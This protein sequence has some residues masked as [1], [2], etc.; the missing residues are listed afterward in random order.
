MKFICYNLQTN[1]FWRILKI[2]NLFAP[3]YDIPT[4]HIGIG[5]YNM[6]GTSQTQAL[7]GEV[8]PKHCAQTPGEVPAGR[9]GSCNDRVK[10][11]R[12]NYDWNGLSFWNLDS[13]GLKL[14]LIHWLI[15][16]LVGWFLVL[17]LL[18]DVY[19]GKATQVVFGWSLVDFTQLLIYPIVGW[20]GSHISN[21]TLYIHVIQ[22]YIL[23][24]YIYIFIVCIYIFTNIYIYMYV[25]LW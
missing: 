6:T 22:L 23:Y 12:V 25:C 9:H 15:D 1:E 7:Q 3:F 20:F 8:L 5:R 19:L 18:G 10:L 11:K 24:I 17:T 13:L 16:W 2:S 4:L 21:Y 14:I